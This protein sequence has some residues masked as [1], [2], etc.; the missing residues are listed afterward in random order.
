MHGGI[1]KSLERVVKNETSDEP[2]SPGTLRVVFGSPAEKTAPESY[3]SLY[4]VVLVSD[5]LRI[6]F[7]AFPTIPDF[8]QIYCLRSPNKR[9]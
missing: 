7:F 2:I 9:L 8:R 1:N 3:I 6:F 4:F 5:N